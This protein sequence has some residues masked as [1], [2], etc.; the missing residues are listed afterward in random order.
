MEDYKKYLVLAKDKTDLKQ[1][2]KRQETIFQLENARS[3]TFNVAG[4]TSHLYIKTSNKLFQLYLEDDNYE[5]AL[6]IAKES[7]DVIKSS[8]DIKV[9][10]R[11]IVN[12]GFAYL[13]N[14]NI[15]E[16]KD[17]AHKYTFDE[18]N[19]EFPYYCL[20]RSAISQV[21]K[22]KE[23]QLYF[24]L[25]AYKAAYTNDS[26]KKDLA[27]I[28][29]AIALYYERN[30][31]NKEAY[32]SY[33]EIFN[34]ATELSLFLTDEERFSFLIRLSRLAI[35]NDNNTLAI[36]LL[37]KINVSMK[38]KLSRQHPLR[39]IVKRLLKEIDETK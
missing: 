37:T 16:A 19:P 8:S 35:K 34:K 29:I 30:K 2:A 11:A 1:F 3:E 10:S 31:L 15:T 4:P 13:K 33:L 18:S 27:N 7:F 6:D 9:K 25:E 5:E 17:I 39:S 23:D 26:S 36:D 20:F 28:L 32:L 21:Y 14:G 12:L 22:N 24:L 38:K